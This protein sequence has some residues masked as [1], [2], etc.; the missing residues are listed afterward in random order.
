MP[1]DMSPAKRARLRRSLNHTPLLNHPDSCPLALMWS[2]RLMVELQGYRKLLRRDEICDDELAGALGLG[3]LIDSEDYRPSSAAQRLRREQKRFTLDH[4]KPDYPEPLSSNL[5]A[6]AQLIGLDATE[7]AI[8]GFC[9][10]MHGDPVLSR[11]VDLFGNVGFNRLARV[12]A[13]LLELPG[14]AIQQALSREGRLIACGVLDIDFQPGLQLDHILNFNSRDLL[15]QLRFHRGAAQ[16]LFKHSFRRSRL[17]VLELS[18][19][20]HLGD[21]VQTTL[22][23]LRKVMARE[24]HGVNILIYGPPGTGKTELCRLLAETL[25]V[26]LFEI[27]CTDSDG[28]PITGNQRLSA[29]SS[30]MGV[31]QGKQAL[32]M[33]DE[34]EDVFAGDYGFSRRKTNKAQKGWINRMLE[35]NAKPCFWLSNDI[36][37]LDAAYIRRFDI[38]IEAPNPTRPQRERIIRGLSDERLSDEMIDTL[39]QHEALTP[40][41]FERAFQVARTIHPRAGHKLESSLESLLDSTLKAQGHTLLS[42]QKTNA[43]PALYTPELVNADTSLTELAKGLRRHPEARLCFYGPPGTGKTAFAGWLAQQLGKPLHSKRVSDLVSAFVGETEKNLAAAFRQAEE[44]SAVLLLDEVDSFLQDRTKARAQ[45]EITAVNEMLTQMESFSG[46]F[47]ASTNLMDNLDEAS[48]RRFDCK[49]HFGYLLPE[50]SRTLL[51]AHL[52]E[53]G[54]DDPKQ[55]AEAYVASLTRL[56]PGDFAAVR[57]RARFKPLASAGE[58]VQALSQEIALKKGGQQRPI[59]FVH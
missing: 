6:M 20:Q 58:L 42:Q 31:L 44:E 2:F 24:R 35:E 59:G 43:L 26:D 50:Q 8:L 53:L 17:S 27:A 7:I 40:A 37:C 22:S 46:L 30:A 23:Y 48:L 57:R 33:L 32:V 16:E 13:T 11:S 54:L 34:I 21:R 52:K 45:W 38:I 51:R 28:D 19:Y 1:F 14:E 10:L 41:V 25:E 55:S 4:P 18:D 15:N 9:V 47:I 56:A 49:I 39:A 36:A 3:P 12:L 5:R 29:L